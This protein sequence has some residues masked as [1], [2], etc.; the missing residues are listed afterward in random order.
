MGAEIQQHGLLQPLIH[1]PFAGTFFGDAQR[2]AIQQPDTGLDRFRDL[3]GDFARA[4]LRA[5]LES[6][7]DGLL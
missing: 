4:D 1:D 6:G 3:G 2:A 7:L 5:V